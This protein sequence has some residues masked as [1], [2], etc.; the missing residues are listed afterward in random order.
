MG[1]GGNLAD[2][3]VGLAV[4]ARQERC[5]VRL[6]RARTHARAAAAMRDAEGL[7]QVEVGDIRTPLAGPGQA[8]QG[9]H[10]GAVG[11]DLAPWA[12]TISQISTT[13][14]SNTPWVDG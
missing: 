5:Q 8:D 12:W 7:V 6:H 14:S 10:V 4:P 11:V 13:S 1:G 3:A 2:A 9:I